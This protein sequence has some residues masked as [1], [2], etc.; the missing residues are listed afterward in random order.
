MS[1]QSTPGEAH[2]PCLLTNAHQCCLSVPI[3][4]ASPMP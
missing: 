3:S 4:A 1:C 2:L